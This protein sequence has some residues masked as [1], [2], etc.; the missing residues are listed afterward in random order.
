MRGG[1]MK[2]RF[3]HCA[4]LHLGAQPLKLEERYNDFY[5]TFSTII[6]YAI[7]NEIKLLLISG[8]LFHIKN[9]N[10]KTLLKTT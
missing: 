1:N 6:D 2:N 5:N 3:I 8:D 9:I 7:K 10:S 4:D